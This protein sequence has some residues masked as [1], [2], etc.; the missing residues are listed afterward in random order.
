MLWVGR[1]GY[2]WDEPADL[3]H[4]RARWSPG[5]P[6]CHRDHSFTAEM[7]MSSVPCTASVVLL[8]GRPGWYFWRQCG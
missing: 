5:R 8:E 3:Y 6:E 2:A 1:P 4:V 7:A